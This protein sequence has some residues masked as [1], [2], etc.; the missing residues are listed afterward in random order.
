MFNTPINL[1]KSVF[2]HEF[3]V[4]PAD[5]NYYLA[6]FCRIH[7]MHEEFW[8]QAL[9]AVEKYL[10][11]SIIC[12]GDSAKAEKGDNGHDIVK[13]W[14]KHKIALGEDAVV[15][16]QKPARLA[17]DWWRNDQLKS[18]IQRINRMGHPDSRY[19][20][21]SFSNHNDDYFKLDE[22]VFQLRRTTIGMDWIVGADWDAEDLIEYYGKTY[23]EALR[24]KSR[25][26]IRPIR[27]PSGRF[28]RIGEEAADVWQ[29]WNFSFTRDA[30]DINKP[31]PSSLTSTPTA[32]NSEIFLLIEA[33]ETATIDA[34]VRERI[35][36]LTESIHLH[37]DTK[38]ELTRILQTKPKK[39]K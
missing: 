16:L 29:A 8:S 19:G 15:E 14:E 5:R 36:W 26:Q 12:N 32:R 20:M 3:F 11:A 17:E 21:T 35:N 10:K 22:L 27:M 30:Q 9:Q 23:R 7:K 25:S 18:F 34:G 24:G 39:Q 1:F 33:L 13:L 6:R 28:E 38:A 31:Y 4:E 2:A 37:K